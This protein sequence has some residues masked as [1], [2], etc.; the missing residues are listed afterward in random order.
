[1]FLVDS[2][3]WIEYLRPRGNA[4]IKARVRDLLEKDEAA[5]CGIVITEVLRGV[6]EDAAYEALEG[7]FSALPCLPL[8]EAVFVRAAQW[9]R[10]LQQAGKTLP[11]TDLLIGAAAYGH[12]AVLHADVDF[13][14][15]A[16]STGLKQEYLKGDRVST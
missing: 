3:A 8:S 10:R 2:S 11:T 13:G 15:L 1:M 6:R 5:V 9:G 4:G 14:L 7:M 12:V 16:S